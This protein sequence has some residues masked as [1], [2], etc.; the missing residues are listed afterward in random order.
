MSN[1]LFFKKNLF[2]NTDFTGRFTRYVSNV[3]LNIVLVEYSPSRIFDSVVCGYKFLV[4]C[5]FHPVFYGCL[6]SRSHL[7]Q[8]AAFSFLC[9]SHLLLENMVYSNEMSYMLI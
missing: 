9:L 5:S 2:E 4:D 3:V 7:I 6:F 8:S 1:L